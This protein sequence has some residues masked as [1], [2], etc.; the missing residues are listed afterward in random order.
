MNGKAF[1]VEKL[2]ISESLQKKLI[3]RKNKISKLCEYKAYSSTVTL[4]IC[5]SVLSFTIK[6][7][8]F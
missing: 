3:N 1:L 5:H 7:L 8:R 4:L 6:F 2:K